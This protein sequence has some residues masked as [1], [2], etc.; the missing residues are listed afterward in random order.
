MSTTSFVIGSISALGAQAGTGFSHT[1]SNEV[2]LWTDG[3]SNDLCEQLIADHSSVSD[4][5]ITQSGYVKIVSSGTITWGSAT[6][7]RDALGFTGATTVMSGGEAIAPNRSPLLWIPRQPESPVKGIISG[8]GSLAHRSSTMQAVDG[9]MVYR[10][11]GDPIR[12]ETWVWKN[13]SPAQYWTTDED[14]GE[15]YQ[16]A[17]AVLGPRMKFYMYMRQTADEASGDEVSLTGAIGPYVATGRNVAT[18][19]KK[20]AVGFGHRECRFDFKL[21]AISTPEYTQ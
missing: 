16:F 5:Y 4:C 18:L 20:V 7:W 8:Q 12:D 2:Y 14:D 10:E 1:F 19:V 21:D 9:T 13:I 3:G 15:L 17:Q 11:F 6:E